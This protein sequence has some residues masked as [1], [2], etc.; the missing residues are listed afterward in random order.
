MKRHFFVLA[1]VIISTQLQAQQDT[2]QMD[3]AVITASK[4]E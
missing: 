4:Y 1:A 3:E 2:T